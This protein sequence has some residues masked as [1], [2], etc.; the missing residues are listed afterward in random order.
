MCVH[1]CPYDSLSLKD[2]KVEVN[3]V[4]CEGCGTCSATCLRAAVNVKNITP[5][6]VQNQIIASLEG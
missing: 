4:L 6:Q 3:E 1:V 5:Q 2:G